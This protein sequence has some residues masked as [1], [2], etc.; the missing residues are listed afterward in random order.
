M[1]NTK[2]VYLENSY[3]GCSKKY[4]IANKNNKFSSN[5]GVFRLMLFRSVNAQNTLCW[6]D[7]L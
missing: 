1:V 3:V 6:F 4:N 5:K 7:S 2:C